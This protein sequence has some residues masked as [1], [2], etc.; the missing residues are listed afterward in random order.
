MLLY[1]L[2]AAL[3]VS[4]LVTIGLLVTAL[5]RLPEAKNEAQTE[6]TVRE[7]FAKNREELGT[8]SRHLREEVQGAVRQFGDSTTQQVQNLNAS[9][10]QTIG[11]FSSRLDTLVS[12]N[13]HKLDT[14]KTTVEV[15]LKSLQEDNG[16]RIDQ[17]RATVDEKLQGT[18]EKRLGEAFKQVGD[19]LEHVQRGLVEMQALATGVGDLKKVLTN[20][21][22]RGTWGEFQIGA[23]LA[24]TLN[25]DQYQQNVATKKHSKESVEYAVRMPGREADPES[26]VWL[27]ID[28]KF[29]LEDYH[30]LLEAQD[31]GD[32]EAVI[33]YGKRLETCIRSSAREIRD[34]YINPPTT[35]D[36]AI[37]FLPTESLY[38]EVLR[39][40][41]L[42]D[43]LQRD[44]RVTVAGPTTLCAL[45]NSLQMGFRTLAIQKRASEVWR[46]L[47]AV[48]TEFG[49]FG[50]IL[51]KVQTKLGEAT[52]NIESAA[53]KS[54]TIVTKL[55]SVEALPATEAAAMLPVTEG[56]EV[57]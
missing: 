26:E 36:F 52:K 32:V 43:S 51:E 56:L 30:Q 21:K 22:S 38:A 1:G 40:P 49:K 19:R 48:K 45:L 47:G 8:S 7:E 28:S 53:Q 27:P 35:T 18:L 24:E 6:R 10:V 20:V 14:L 15:Q 17:M 39:R 5:R 25:P 29:P 31:R 34:K 3:L 23:L 2:L 44:C 16:K 12:S 42:L 11:L 33:E 37:L 46:V 9:L 13:E 55:K 57:Q 41:G 54:R 4:C 50:D